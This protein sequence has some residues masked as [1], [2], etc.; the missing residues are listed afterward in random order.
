MNET[1]IN[2]RETVTKEKLIPSAQLILL[3]RILHRDKHQNIEEF[4]FKQLAQILHYTPMV[5]TN[6]VNNLKYHKICTN[7]G[8]KEKFIRFNLAIPEMWNDVLKRGLFVDPVLK[9]IYTDEVPKDIK[10]VR[11]NISA[12]S[13]YSDVN[14]GSQNYQAIEKNLFYNIQKSNKP[15]SVNDQEGNICLELWK[16]DPAV[17]MNQL[18]DGNAVVDPLSLYLS[19][20]N[21][22]DERIQDALERIIEKYIW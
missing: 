3:Y 14:P 6:A 8:G 11:S 10:K 12:L 9:K 18:T 5:I 19:L 16:Y 22:Y 21:S 15:I 13:D 7:I 17:I 2:R 4:S 1:A 20:K